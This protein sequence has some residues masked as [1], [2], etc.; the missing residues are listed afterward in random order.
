MIT[1]QQA[2]LMR[3]RQA[4]AG[5]SNGFLSQVCEAISGLKLEVIGEPNARFTCPCCHKRT[6]SELFDPALGTGYDVCDHCGWEDDG[7]L[8][9]QDYSGPNHGTI[10]EYRARMRRESKLLRFVTSGVSNIRKPANGERRT[11]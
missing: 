9:D 8:N 1:A 7:T 10:A 5:V 11:L 3:S 4:Y 2:Y 6:L